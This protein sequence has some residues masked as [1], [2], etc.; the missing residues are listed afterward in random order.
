MSPKVI[1][2]SI[3]FAIIATLASTNF[4]TQQLFLKN[5]AFFTPQTFSSLPLII[6]I[7]ISHNHHHRRHHPDE[8]KTTKSIC[9]DFPSDFP[10][11]D[12]NTTSVFCVDSN[13]CCNFTTV[14]AAVDAV[15]ALNPKRTVIWI[16]NGIYF[17]KVM[18]PRNK[19]NITFQGQGYTSTAI[20]WNDTANSAH[21]TFYS[22]SVQVFAPNFIAKNIS[23]MN[24]APIPGPGAVGAQAVAIRISGDSAAFWG[25]GFFG[26]QDTLHDDRGR[27]YFKD[28]YIQGSI[29]FIFGNAKSFY[30][31]CHITSIASPVAAG[32]RVINGVVTAHGR[33][34]KDENSGFAFINCT[35]GGTGRIWLGRAWRPFSTVVF[36]FTNMSDIIAPEGWNDFNDPTRDQTI[37]YGEY[38]C[39]GDGANTTLRAPYAQRLND[40]QASPFL[41]VTFI[42]ADQWLQ[43]YN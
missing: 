11:P 31:N 41:N 17:E 6:P 42:D 27:H 14:Q 9:D 8:K 33:A 32:A 39:S 4:F 5:L 21:G 30:E 22:G 26:A 24:V 43:S 35:I 28:C 40:T 19:S 1:C 18:V 15:G 29:D 2:V 10:P 37:F 23:F 34:S 20:V 38:N 16:N 7:P 25:C 12:T 36:S 3:F 13:G